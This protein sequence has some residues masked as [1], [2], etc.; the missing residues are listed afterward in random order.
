MS[1]ISSTPIQLVSSGDLA[2]AFGF[3]GPNDSF[4]AF[5]RELGIRPIRR[6]PNYYD[7]KHVR[8]QLDAAQGL[9]ASLKMAD[10]QVDLIARRRARRAAQ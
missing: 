4:R 1:Y 5:C 3:A 8:V 6:N 7:T 10:E 2:A 9:S